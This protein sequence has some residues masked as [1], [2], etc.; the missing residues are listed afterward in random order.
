MEI[1][2]QQIVI[3]GNHIKHTDEWLAF[4][5]RYLYHVI[6]TKTGLCFCG[7]NADTWDMPL[8][9]SNAPTIDEILQSDNF[10]SQCCQK[11]RYTLE[12]PDASTGTEGACSCSL[13]LNDLLATVQRV[14]D[15]PPIAIAFWFIDREEAYLK[16]AELCKAKPSLARTAGVFAS[17]SL[18]IPVLNITTEE[19][20][21]RVAELST[22]PKARLALEAECLYPFREPGVYIQMNKGS[23]KRLILG[24]LVSI[25]VAD[26]S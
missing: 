1:T 12:L 26:A 22:D 8:R 9:K 2:A 14:Q 21:A 7:R 4:N 5:R 16:L 25:E 20:K 23:H 19:I 10:C 13:T 17:P 15:F 11:I 6:D 3:P 18:D 24:Q